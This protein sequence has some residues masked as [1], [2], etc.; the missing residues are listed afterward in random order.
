MVKNVSPQ[1]KWESEEN[2][3][4]ASVTW[5]IVLLSVTNRRNDSETHQEDISKYRNQQVEW[6]QDDP[7]EEQKSNQNSLHGS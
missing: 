2:P 5:V 6:P 3:Q 1:A 4:M 7:D